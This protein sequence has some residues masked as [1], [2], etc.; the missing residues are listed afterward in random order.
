MGDPSDERPDWEWLLAAERHHHVLEDLRARFDEVLADLEEAAG[1]RSARVQRPLVILGSLDGVLTGIRQLR[2]TQ[3]LETE[4][5]AGLLVPTL[6]EMLRVK[7]WLFVTRLTVRDYL[8]TVVLCERLG[9]DGV[10]AALRPFDDL[11]RQPTRASPLA[12]L[13]ERLAAGE[14]KDRASVDL[15]TYKGLVPPW[16]D[17]GRVVGR[18]RRWAS[19][20]AGVVL[21]AGP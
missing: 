9:E 5:V 21:E 8:D 7:A 11:Y 3:P 13:A 1:W 14:P 10:P 18:G 20:V 6:P 19:V 17:W 12:E 16:N 2:R 15:A 4:T